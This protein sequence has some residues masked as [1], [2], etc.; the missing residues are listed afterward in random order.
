MKQ[1]VA[2][3]HMVKTVHLFALTASTEIVILRLEN[4]FAVPDLMDYCK[5]LSIY[6]YDLL[7]A[8]KL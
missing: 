6:V 8:D 2:M 3:E 4:A 1:N 5:L 7:T